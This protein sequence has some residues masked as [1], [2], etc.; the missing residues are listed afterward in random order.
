MRD[1]RLKTQNWELKI[2]KSR[3]LSPASRSSASPL[4][5]GREGKSRRNP[6]DLFDQGVS[7]KTSCKRQAVS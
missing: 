6:Q 7:D 4:S 5:S 1:S 2:L 3:G